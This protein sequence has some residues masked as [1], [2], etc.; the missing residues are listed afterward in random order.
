VTDGEIV[1]EEQKV[2]DLAQ[3]HASLIHA[4]TS[5]TGVPESEVRSMFDKELVRL[6]TGA[7]VDTYLTVRTM[8]N[9]LRMLRSRC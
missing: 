4:L 6:S 3:S 9:V 1:S 2:H 8:S 5:M 7:T